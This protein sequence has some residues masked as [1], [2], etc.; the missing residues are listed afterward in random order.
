MAME[1]V[2][3]L[4]EVMKIIKKQLPAAYLNIEKYLIQNLNTL[5]NYPP[6][7]PTILTDV[8]IVGNASSY[9]R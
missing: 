5:E 8:S 3:I 9:P 7:R 1:I 2:Q 6:P 4:R